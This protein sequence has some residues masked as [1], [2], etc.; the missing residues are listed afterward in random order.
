MIIPLKKG[1]SKYIDFYGD[2][3]KIDYLTGA[4]EQYLLE[5]QYKNLNYPE[6]AN[7]KLASMTVKYAIKEWEGLK[8]EDGKDVKI[9]LVNNELPENIFQSLLK[10]QSLLFE[11]AQEIMKALDFSEEDKKKYYFAESRGA[12]ARLQEENKNIQ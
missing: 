3:I 8:D 10:N 2:K 4:Q 11:L 7:F 12:K 5:E 6:L 9:E 1:V